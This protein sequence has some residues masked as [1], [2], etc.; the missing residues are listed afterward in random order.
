M[1]DLQAGHEKPV[2][3]EIESCED[4][5]KEEEPLHPTVA[6]AERVNDVD[7]ILA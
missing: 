6:P 4:R 3:Y 1:S 7:Q 2:L 5:Q